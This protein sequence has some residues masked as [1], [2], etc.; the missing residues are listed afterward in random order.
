MKKYRSKFLIAFQIYSVVSLMLFAAGSANAQTLAAAAQGQEIRRDATEVIPVPPVPDRIRVT[1]PGS[2]PF[3]KGHGVGTQN[4][5][6]KPTGATTFGFVLFTPQA[7]L[8]TDRGKELITHFFSPNPDEANVDPNVIGD[9]QIRVT[10]EHSID[11]S[12]IWAKLE[13]AATNATDPAFVAKDAVAWLLLDVV[14]YRNGPTGGNTLQPGEHGFVQRINT[15]GG[16]APSTG[17]SSTGDV[18][19]QA[20][21]PYEADYFFFTAGN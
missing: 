20:F 17:C 21:V 19:H 1:A 16:L 12:T 4:Y 6:C 2:V 5:I 9:R 13:V 8:F 7:T 10:W 11:T 15:V 3:F 14:G 18:G